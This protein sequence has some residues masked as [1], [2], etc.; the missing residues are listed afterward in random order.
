MEDPSSSMG[1]LGRPS[2]A[3]QGSNSNSSAEM[4]RLQPEHEPEPEPEDE[5]ESRSFE[6]VGLM[7]SPGMAGNLNLND[8]ADSDL[9]C[10]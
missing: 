8:V 2:S 6:R 1:L 7:A 4:S 5:Q 3:V 10:R 9:G